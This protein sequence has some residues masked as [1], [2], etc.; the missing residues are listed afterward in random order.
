M[1]WFKASQQQSST[2][3]L[4]HCPQWDG[5]ENQKGKSEKSCEL[6]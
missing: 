1:S 2:R 3:P 4:A 6:R 5:G